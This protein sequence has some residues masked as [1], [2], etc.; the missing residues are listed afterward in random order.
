MVEHVD[1]DKM[2][3]IGHRPW[4]AHLSRKQWD[5]SISLYFVMTAHAQCI[6]KPDCVSFL[7]FSS[8]FLSCL[9]KVLLTLFTNV[10][11]VMNGFDTIATYSTKYFL[12]F[13]FVFYIS[14][15]DRKIVESGRCWLISWSVASECWWSSASCGSLIFFVCLQLKEMHW[16]KFFLSI[17]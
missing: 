13:V 7:F 4:K 16:N 9:A 3:L 12:H 2:I 15:C 8:L 17:S 14:M 10:L 5:V 11:F 1:I 6:K